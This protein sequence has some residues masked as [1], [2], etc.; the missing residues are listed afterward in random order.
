MKEPRTSTFSVGDQVEVSH[1][2]CKYD[3]RRGKVVEKIGGGVYAVEMPARTRT[4]AGRAGKTR[5]V[6]DAAETKK[7]KLGSLELVAKVLA[8]AAQGSLFD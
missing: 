8:K 1:S 3:K 6:E 5:Q 4:V 7:L 2:N